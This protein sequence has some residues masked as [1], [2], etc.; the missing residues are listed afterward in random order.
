MDLGDEIVCSMSLITYY[1]QSP[2]DTNP[3]IA[4]KYGDVFEMPKQHINGCISVK[5]PW[6]GMANAYVRCV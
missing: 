3:Y 6:F 5:H 4:C 1:E 2:E